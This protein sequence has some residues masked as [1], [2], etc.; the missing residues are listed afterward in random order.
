MLMVVGEYGRGLMTPIYHE[1]RG[2]FFDKKQLITPK[3]VSR[4]IKENGRNGKP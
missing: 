3:E 2:F 1:V 4:N